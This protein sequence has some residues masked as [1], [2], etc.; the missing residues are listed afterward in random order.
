MAAP[1][2]EAQ[3][4]RRSRLLADRTEVEDVVA[5]HATL[6]AAFV[7]REV[8]A[9]GVGVLAGEPGHAEVDAH[10]LVGGEREEHV[11]GRAY[12]FPR[13]RREGDGGGRNVALHVECAPSPHL[14]LDEVARPRIP[15][16]FAGIGEDGVRVGHQEERRPVSAV[17]PRDE[18][19]TVG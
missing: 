14:A 19:R 17:E 4:E 8:G 13:E 5:E 1:T 16:P 11:A 3:P 6:A 2:A 10:L 12:A 18:I 7:D 9:H 15:G